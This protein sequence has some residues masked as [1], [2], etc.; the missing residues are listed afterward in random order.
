MH[1]LATAQTTTGLSPQAQRL[2]RTNE[3]FPLA[4]PTYADFRQTM[5]QHIAEWWQGQEPQ[6]AQA[7]EIGTGTGIATEAVLSIHPGIEVT[8]IDSD[9]HA[10]EACLHRLQGF[11][12][13]FESHCIDALEYLESQSPGSID[14][15]FTVW[16][17]HNIEAPKRSS[18]LRGMRRCLADGGMIIIGDKFA[19]Q[20]A[21]MQEAAFEAQKRLIR[22]HYDSA[23]ETKIG[24]D[25]LKHYD[26]DER[27]QFFMNDC[28]DTLKKH[29]GFETVR[30]AWRG[31]MEAI[32]IARK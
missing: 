22:H 23:N 3:I 19:Y 7:L 10:I 14:L 1:S 28:I 30:G 24:D 11:E 16:T 15:I 2:L 4:V 12:Q 27:R 5:L 26:Q 32:I 29:G 20:K 25:L 6:V 31:G 9:P 21:Q 18:I 17:L 13:Q 8:T